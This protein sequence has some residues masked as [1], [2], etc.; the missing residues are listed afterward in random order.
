MR[1]SFVDSSIEVTGKSLHIIALR[2]LLLI[3]EL[4]AKVFFFFYVQSSFINYWAIILSVLNCFLINSISLLKLLI[5][6]ELCKILHYLLK[7]SIFI[8]FF[9]S[10]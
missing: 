8:F 1:L 9:I 5:K 6:T 3:N 2:L 7:S 10:Y 4:V